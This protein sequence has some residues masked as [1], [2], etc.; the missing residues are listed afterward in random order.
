MKICLLIVTNI[1]AIELLLQLLS[2][3]HLIPFLNITERVP[4]AR[5]YWSSEGQEHSTLNNHGWH[6]YN[7]DDDSSYTNIAIIGDSFIEGNQVPK[8][9]LVAHRVQSWIDQQPSIINTQIISLGRGNTGPAHYLE[10]F[11]LAIEKYKIN[12]AFIFITLSNDF[13]NLLKD[14]VGP[15]S[16]PFYYIVDSD[17]NIIADPA[18]KP[19]NEGYVKQLREDFNFSTNTFPRFIKSHILSYRIIKTLLNSSSLKRDDS[20][21]RANFNNNIA[22]RLNDRGI[23]AFAFDTTDNFDKINSFELIK[24][25]INEYDLLA[26]KNDVKLHIISIPCFPKDLLSA[27]PDSATNWSS[28]IENLDIRLPD[29]E[30]QSFCQSRNIDYSSS[31]ERIEKDKLTIGEIKSLSYF[32]GSGHWTPHGHEYFSKTVINKLYT[33]KETLK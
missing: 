2:L 32:E 24:Y 28:I 16:P 8:N 3:F 20:D 22:S 17:K 19:A 4:Y 27:Y 15:T 21:K 14:S 31:F 18:T 12:R 7:F 26:K 6:Y 29:K 33:N 25:F 23:N 13:R 1:I 11:K 10:F 30:L 5:L 9:A